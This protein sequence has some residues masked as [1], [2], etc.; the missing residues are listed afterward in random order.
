MARTET[1]TLAVFCAKIDLEAVLQCVL[2][3]EKDIGR[4][5]RVKIF[6]NKKQQRERSQARS[7]HFALTLTAMLKSLSQV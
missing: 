6:I 7:R 5:R 3:S 1:K 2:T 4:W